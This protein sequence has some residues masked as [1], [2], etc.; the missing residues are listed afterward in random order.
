MQLHNLQEV[1]EFISVVNDC[2][3]NVYMTSQMG[4]KYNLKSRFSQYVAIGA[5]LEEHGNDLE[6]WCDDEED[7][8][9]MVKWLM[10]HKNVR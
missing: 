6:L 2:K 8:M 4:D 9:R 3:G 10:K 5:L 7:K 1:N